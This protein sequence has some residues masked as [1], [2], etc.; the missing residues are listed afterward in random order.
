MVA[1]KQ[2]CP[3]CAGDTVDIGTVRS[4]FSH[5][6]FAFRQCDTCGLSFIANPRLDFTSIYDAAYYCGEGA[7][8]FVNY[9]G[10][11]GDPDTIRTYEWA[12]ITHCVESL[13]GGKDV[14]WLDFGCGL[15][16]LVRY[17]RSQ[18][19]PNV[20]GYDEGWGAD[21]AREHGID[22]LEQDQLREH[23]GTFDVITAIE[24]IE[25][26]P[27]PLELMQGIASLLK[28][29][30][31]FFLT[32]GNAAP[33]RDALTRWKYVHPDVHVTYYEPRTLATLYERVGLDPFAAGFLPGHEG[34]IR[35]KVLR[36]L[37]LSSRNLLERLVPWRLAS[38]VVD[39]RYKVTDQVF[40]RKPP[41]HIR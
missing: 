24:V 37:G 17:A 34:I 41:G 1:T 32:T 8:S 7:D 4:D 5:S 19:F 28:P 29:G 31:V 30:G 13:C 33:H 38:R 6:D 14:K 22:V 10:E 25:H 3:I 35:Y 36:T 20:Y 18:G 39:R 2:E 27:G 26:I 12:G 16:G 15:G 21:W 23:E 9:V 40:A 11:M